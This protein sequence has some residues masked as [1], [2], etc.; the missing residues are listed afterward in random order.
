MIRD[1]FPLEEQIHEIQLFDTETLKIRI[2]PHKLARLAKRMRSFRTEFASDS[3]DHDHSST[4]N[5][6]TI[7][8]PESMFDHSDWPIQICILWFSRLLMN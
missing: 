7:H 3:L 5:E 2:V 4:L 8:D 6:K 1:R